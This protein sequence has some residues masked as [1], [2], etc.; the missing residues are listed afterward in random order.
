[1]LRIALFFDG[2]GQGRALEKPIN[3]MHFSCQNF[4]L[5]TEFQEISKDLKNR[6]NSDGPRAKAPDLLSETVRSR[7]N[8]S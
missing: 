6:A 2:V 7:K 4:F 1:L 8:T 5:V 3:N